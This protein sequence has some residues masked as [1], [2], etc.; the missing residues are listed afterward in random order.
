MKKIVR[1]LLYVLAARWAWRKIKRQ[2]QQKRL[3]KERSDELEEQATHICCPKE[4]YI[5]HHRPDHD[6]ERE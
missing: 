6:D 1:T 3:A 5:S 2:Q 4:H